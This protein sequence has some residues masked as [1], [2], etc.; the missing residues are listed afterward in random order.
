MPEKK[1]ATPA[2]RQS[3]ARMEPKMIAAYNRNEIIISAFI[4][5]FL[6]LHYIRKNEVRAWQQERFL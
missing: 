2:M 5:K 6:C 3:K 4:Q 1:P